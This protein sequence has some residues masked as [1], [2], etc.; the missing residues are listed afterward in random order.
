MAVVVKTNT[1]A[2]AI[3]DFKIEGQCPSFLFLFEMPFLFLSKKITNFYIF[4]AKL[5]YFCLKAVNMVVFFA[6][7]VI[8]YFIFYLQCILLL[9]DTMNEKMKQVAHRVRELREVLDMTTLEVA[10]LAGIRE[11]LYCDY[12]NANIEITVSDLYSIAAAFQIDPTALLTGE[13]PKMNS[14]TIVRNGQG[15]DLE[16]HQGYMFSS[17]ASNYTGRDMEPMLVYLKNDVKDVEIVQHNGQEFN[18][19]LQGTIRVNIGAK[20]FE[21]NQGDSIY[22]NSS[23]KHSQQA[24]TPTAVFLAVINEIS[25]KNRG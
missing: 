16:R 15:E 19:V 17:L 20:T 23:I 21:L 14:Y 24:V 4:F 8:K 12:E 3:T 11:D 2:V 18:Y 22:F 9:E 25:A 5:I 6:N 1:V 13:T 7:K 10:H